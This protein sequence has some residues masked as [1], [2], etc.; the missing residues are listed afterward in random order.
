MGRTLKASI[1]VDNGRAAEFIR[2]RTYKDKSRCYECGVSRKNLCEIIIVSDWLTHSIT[3]LLT[4]LSYSASA[5]SLPRA[6]IHPIFHHAAL[7]SL[8]P[9]PSSSF[10]VCRFSFSASPFRPIFLCCSPRDR[11]LAT[12]ATNVHVT[13]LANES[14]RRRKRESGRKNPSMSELFSSLYFV[15][16]LLA[17][18]CL[19]PWQ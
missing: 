8:L 16:C 14:S 3:S 10:F 15:G 19:C 1:A 12:S 11:S 18:R 2:R 9:V 4:H 5:H 13:C 6:F 17:G 7:S